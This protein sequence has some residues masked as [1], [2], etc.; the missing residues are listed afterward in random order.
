MSILALAGTFFLLA[1]PRYIDALLST[2]ERQ[3]AAESDT[4]P[5]TFGLH[6]VFSVVCFGASAVLGF[7]TFFLSGGIGSLTVCLTAIG[8]G[9]LL[10]RCGR[11]RQPGLE[12]S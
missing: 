3:Q 12:G 6:R 5:R 11:K 9:L 10:L 2:E 8:G 7:Q 1:F 4:A